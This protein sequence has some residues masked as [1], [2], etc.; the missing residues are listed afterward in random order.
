MPEVEQA[1]AKVAR[2]GARK[3]EFDCEIAE[4]DDIFDKSF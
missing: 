1:K 4:F 3:Q 2:Q